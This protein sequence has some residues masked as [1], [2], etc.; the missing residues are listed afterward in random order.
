MRLSCGCRN[1]DCRER[2]KL[3]PAYSLLS[4]PFAPAASGEPTLDCGD[5]LDKMDKG[6]SG[7]I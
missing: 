4:R 6:L 5:R 7:L 3:P 2:E 1:K